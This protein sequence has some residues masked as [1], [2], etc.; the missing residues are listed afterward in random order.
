MKRFILIALFSSIAVASVQSATLSKALV[1]GTNSISLTPMS[2]KQVTLT[3]GTEGA[4]TVNFYDN[5]RTN[6]IYTNNAFSTRVSYTTNFTVNYTNANGVVQTNLFDGVWTASS[7]TAAA[8]NTLPV[9]LSITLPASSTKTLTVPIN[10][11]KGLSATSDT[12]ATVN[13]IYTSPF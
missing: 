5:S 4:T 1:F 9:L 7:T 13:I 2:I 6:I 12:N 8:T 10:T 11:V 3:T